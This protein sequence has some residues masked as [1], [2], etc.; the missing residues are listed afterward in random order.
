M[1]RPLFT[2]EELSKGAPSA[3][4]P[5]QPAVKVGRTCPGVRKVALCGSGTA[6]VHVMLSPAWIHISLGRKAITCTALSG[7]CAPANAC[8]DSACTNLEKMIAA[9]STR[10]QLSLRLI[11]KSPESPLALLNRRRDSEDQTFNKD[12]QTVRCRIGADAVTCS[13]IRCFT[14][15]IGLQFMPISPQKRRAN[16]E[17]AR[18]RVFFQN[19]IIGECHRRPPGFLEGDRCLSE[20]GCDHSPALGEARR[21]ARPPPCA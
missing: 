6:K 5:G 7:L 8:Q 18:G 20:S 16:Q 19:A 2:H 3:V 9:H 15:R 10:N 14:V 4:V 12:V 11:S 1:I 17:C 13:G 21:N